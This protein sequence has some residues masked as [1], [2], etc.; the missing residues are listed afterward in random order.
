MFARRECYIA[1]ALFIGLSFSSPK[2]IAQTLIRGPITQNM[3]FRRSNRP[4]IV[5]ANIIRANKVGMSCRT[6]QIL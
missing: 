1:V 3:I 2:G 6:A 4:Y 5:V